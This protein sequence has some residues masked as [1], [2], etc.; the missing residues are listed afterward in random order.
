M[1][2]A[3]V[4]QN[5]SYSLSPKIHQFWMNHYN[6]RGT[7]ELVD[8][9]AQR[10]PEI[11]KSYQGANITIPFKEN[12]IPH[13]DALTPLAQSIGAVNTIY[14]SDHQKWIGD[15]TDCLALVELIQDFP[16][17]RK[18][19][20]LGSGGAAK[21]ALC[22]LKNL[23][24]EAIVC[25]RRPI[26]EPWQ[27]WENRHDVMQYA[28]IIIN[29]TPLGMNN[30]GCPL[31][32]LPSSSCLVIDMVYYPVYTPLIK[33]ALSAGHSI[34]NGLELLIVQAR[35]SFK[36]WWGFLPGDESI[37]SLNKQLKI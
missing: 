10:L 22:A 35:H 26:A 3:V 19:L 6:L 13:L 21:A 9:T 5:I 37:E 16:T 28:D 15:N 20:V 14:L 23:T 2:L 25:S 12:I 8:T 24:I 32:F 11:L 17:A 29:A 18:A 1:K 30:Q 31:D 36:T 4:G 27:P 34:R 7:Y 33:L